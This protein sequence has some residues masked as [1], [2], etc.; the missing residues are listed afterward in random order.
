[1]IIHKTKR[2]R[3]NMS[4]EHRLLA[5]C[6]RQFAESGENRDTIQRD[7]KAEAFHNVY[8]SQLATLQAAL[9]WQSY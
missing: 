1:M 2:L 8:N 4:E 9:P 7:Y 6:L 5:S 3:D